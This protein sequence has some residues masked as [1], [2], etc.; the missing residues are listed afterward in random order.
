MKVEKTNFSLAGN[1]KGNR[2]NNKQQ[3]S[4]KRHFIAIMERIAAEHQK[5]N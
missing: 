4:M 3:E 1:G 5:E 2:N